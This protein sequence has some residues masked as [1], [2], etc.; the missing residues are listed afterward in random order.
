VIL[1]VFGL[2]MSAIALVGSA[3]LLLSEET[4]DRWLLPLVA[5]AAGSLIGGA[6]FHMLPAGVEQLG[7]GTA[8]WVW[9]G[10]GFLT[11]FLLE[12]FLS[13]HHCHHATHD[14]ARPLNWLIL[15]AD[16][17]HNF[18]GGL[19]I[20]AVFLVDLRLGITAWLAAAAHEV[21]QELGDFGVLVHGGWR[22]RRALLG[23]L[24][25]A[26]TFPVG[27]LL[28]WGLSGRVEVAAMI[29]FGAGN[30][31]YIGCADL[32]P[33]VKEPESVRR[34]LAHFAC[35]FLG[36]GLLLVLRLVFDV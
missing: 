17:L 8:V 11:F 24:L 28:A 3:T 22:P 7:N 12:Q 21:P 2:L 30:F 25:S 32:I 36:L 35:F 10:L 31:L 20:G 13:W 18:L 15:V 4:L 29:P 14:H 1:L 26:L 19:S 6:L 33:E 9:V 27:M 34:A 23:N 5:F 16:G